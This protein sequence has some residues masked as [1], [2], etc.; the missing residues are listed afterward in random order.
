MAKLSPAA[1]WSII[2]VLVIL[3]LVV[4][5]SCVGWFTW[6]LMRDE[7]VHIAGEYYLTDDPIDYSRILC[8]ESGIPGALNVFLPRPSEE[9]TYD[10]RRIGVSGSHI[11][12]V[13]DHWKP[14]DLGEWYFVL[15][16]ETHKY[17]LYSVTEAEYV[18]YLSQNNITPPKLRRR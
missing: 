15:N 6:M 4:I 2:V 8:I 16:Y 3:P 12:L 14:A 17:D 18:R 10:V 1:F 9:G 13:A 11:H 7:Q 5:A